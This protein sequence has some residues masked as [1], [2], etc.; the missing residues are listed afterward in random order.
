MDCSQIFIDEMKFVSSASSSM[1]PPVKTVCYKSWVP[2]LSK[3][4]NQEEENMETLY[5]VIVVDKG[6]NILLD[7][8]IVASSIDEAKFETEVDGVI[9]DNGLCFSD[10]TV[11][12]NP[13]G[14]VKVAVED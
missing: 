8:K 2:K 1:W 6:R 5:S 3:I 10:V 11:L 9:R 7:E 4:E 14:N 12:V 13:L